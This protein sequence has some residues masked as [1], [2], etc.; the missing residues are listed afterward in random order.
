MKSK[1]KYTILTKNIKKNS[2]GLIR[3][4]AK[5]VFI[6]NKLEKNKIS[7]ETAEYEFSQ[8]IN[9]F[10]PA[11]ESS[12]HLGYEGI[13][14][15]S[16]LDNDTLASYIK[17]N[18]LSLSEFSS[19]YHENVDYIAKFLMFFAV[20][21]KENIKSFSTDNIQSTIESITSNNYSDLFDKIAESISEENCT[22][23]ERIL[24]NDLSYEDLTDEDKELIEN[25]HN[26]YMQKYVSPS[27]KDEPRKED[28]VQVVKQLGKKQV[29]NK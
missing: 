18:N 5:L 4:L 10:M 12:I 22:I 3:S 24:D 26:K 7:D 8:F 16:N 21:D 23:I 17:Q 28:L 9:K 13:K 25:Y 1:N 19:N 14:D 2:K 15:I 20:L 29:K 11:I 27:V 6:I